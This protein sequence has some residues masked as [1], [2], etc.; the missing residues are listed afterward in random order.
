MLILSLLRRLFSCSRSSRL[1][2]PGAEEPPQ[3]DAAGPAHHLHA[4]VAAP[5]LGPGLGPRRLRRVLPEP[6]QPG[7]QHQAGRLGHCTAGAPG[8]GQREGGGGQGGLLSG[9]HPADAEER[10][11]R[12]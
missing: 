12:G 10:G 5:D 9:R 7:E 6:A 2:H 3:P 11:K 1:P 4:I 8:H